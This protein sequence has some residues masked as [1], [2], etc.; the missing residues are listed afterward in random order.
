MNMTCAYQLDLLEASHLISVIKVINA[1]S[2]NV[3]KAML[4]FFYFESIQL[5]SHSA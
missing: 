5:L 4:Q 1:D 3:Y 2:L